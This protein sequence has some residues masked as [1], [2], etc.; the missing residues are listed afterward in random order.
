MD[1]LPTP[2]S[3]DPGPPAPTLVLAL[4]VVGAIAW[5]VAGPVG[6]LPCLVTGLLMPYLLRSVAPLSGPRWSLL[7]AAVFTLGGYMGLWV[8][9]RF[10]AVTFLVAGML[11]GA[12]AGFVL[13][14]LSEAVLRRPEPAAPR[15]ALPPA[16]PLP[17]A[18]LPPAG[19]VT[20]ALET[21]VETG[22]GASFPKDPPTVGTVLP[23]DASAAASPVVSVPGLDVTEPEARPEVP[24]ESDPAPPAAEEPEGD[25]LPA[26]VA[27]D[28]S[29]THRPPDAGRVIRH[30]DTHAQLLRLDRETLCGA[31]LRGAALAGADLLREDLSGADLRGADLS[32][33]D[34]SRAN[35]RGANLRGA[36][37]RHAELV[38]ADLTAAQLAGASLSGADLRGA[39]LAEADLSSA[40]LNG[41]NLYGAQLEHANLA[42]I[43]SDLA[44]S[45]PA[46]VPV[47]DQPIREI[48]VD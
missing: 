9:S 3:Q 2:A 27:A 48:S 22:S 42:G 33:A 14:L 10:E 8:G 11:L 15:V 21:P 24:P 1:D 47:P 37:L 35:L 45:W 41:A 16:A 18:A 32:A 19:E 38:R 12:A 26:G 5:Q 17:P 44:T 29:G 43:R 39:R 25:V 46:D 7:H 20:H 23:A 30:K 13:S 40:D 4:I 34:L 6:A 31:D 28:V 36:D